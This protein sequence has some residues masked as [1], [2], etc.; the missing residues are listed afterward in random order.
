M[1]SVP[2]TLNWPCAHGICSTGTPQVI[3]SLWYDCDDFGN[4][5]KWLEIGI[6]GYKTRRKSL[7]RLFHA[8]NSY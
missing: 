2:L 1:I 7:S 4:K 5:A 3:F 8:H 6:W